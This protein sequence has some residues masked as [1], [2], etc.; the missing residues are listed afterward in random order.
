MVTE[1]Y[2]VPMSPSDILLVAK[3]YRTPEATPAEMPY[4]KDSFTQGLLQN[5]DQVPRFSSSL[6]VVLNKFIKFTC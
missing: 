1:K 5:L 3:L 6:L 4:M 2:V